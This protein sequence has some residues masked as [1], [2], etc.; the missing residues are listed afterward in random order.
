ME[1]LEMEQLLQNKD[2]IFKSDFHEK[3]LE[4]KML[5]NIMSGK[6]IK[7]S[8]TWVKYAASVAVML[9]M[10]FGYYSKSNIETKE[11]IV[12]T[13]TNNTNKP[14][15]YV[16]TDGSKIILRK[17]SS[18]SFDENFNTSE[19]KVELKGEAFFDVARNENK[20]FTIKTGNLYTEVLGTSFNINAK[21]EK[22]KVAVVSGLVKV[23]DANNVIRIKPNQEAIYTSQS[24]DLSKHNVNTKLATLWFKNKL[25][26]KGISLKEISDLLKNRFGTELISDN[27]KLLNKRISLTITQNDNTE[28]IIKKINNINEIKIEKTLHSNVLKCTE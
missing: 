2:R 7:K 23:Y 24:K 26:L 9:G 21:K 27:P 14:K 15:T 13:L 11:I 25:R 6:N 17:G 8:F 10:A 3:Q 28:S 18:I 1:N 16:L 5:D 20:I 12:T 4:Y 22:I 19:R